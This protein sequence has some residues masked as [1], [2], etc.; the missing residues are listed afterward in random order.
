MTQFI[1]FQNNKIAYKSEGEGPAL[2]LLHGFLENKNMWKRFSDFLKDDF[3][4]ISIDLPGFGESGVLG[5][6]HSMEFMADCTKAV[7]D[8]EN[9]NECV[10]AGHSMGGYTT[11]AFAE[12]YPEKIKGFCLF[13]SHASEDPDEVKKNRERTVEIVKKDRTGFIAAFI[14]DLFAPDNRARFMPHIRQL[15]EEA[16]KHPTEG[17]TAALLGMKE[18]TS[19]V[20]LLTQ[21]KA[22]VLFIIGKQDSRIPLNK[23]MAQA[24]LPAHAE[25]LIMEHA[26]HMAWLEDEYNT[27]H[28]LRCFAY[29]VLS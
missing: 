26:G 1:D 7:L 3:T 21:T 8:A 29:G 23:I 22:P 16:L 20:A 15:Q 10:M 12:K 5:E 27:I 13:H 4:V 2:V 9:I 25:L 24:M 14:P 18:R 17:I 19:K 6:V 28:K 11:L